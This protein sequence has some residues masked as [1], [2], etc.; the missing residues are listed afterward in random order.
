MK[1]A[2]QRFKKLKVE[3]YDAIITKDVFGVVPSL[4][5]IKIQ[6]ASNTLTYKQFSFLQ[7]NEKINAFMGWLE[8]MENK[9][10]LS[11]VIK[12]G[13]LGGGAQPWSN[14]YIQS[15]YS[16]GLSRADSE[17]KK[18]GHKIYKQTPIGIGIQE[19]FHVDRVAMLYTRTFEDL[20]TVTSVMN[21]EI[22]RE[23]TDGL[24]NIL[25]LG[26]AGGKGPASLTKDLYDLISN[27]VDKIGITRA[28]TIARTEVIR[29]HHQAT[30]NEYEQWGIT[31]VKILAEWATA[32]FGVCPICSTLQ[33][34]I[35][36]LEEI[37]GLIPIHPNCRC[38]A[39]PYIKEDEKKSV[40]KKVAPKKV[41]PKKVAPKKVEKEPLYIT[42]MAELN[43]AQYKTER[44]FAFND[45]GKQILKKIGGET[46]ISFNKQEISVLNGAKDVVHNHP[47][48]TSFSI[49]DC[50][51]QRTTGAKN[52]WA[53]GVDYNY[54]MWDPS[55]SKKE[56]VKEYDK[57]EQEMFSLLKKNMQ[58]KFVTF[59]QA[60]LIHH[61]HVWEE[62]AK[63][64][65][66]KYERI[67]VA[68]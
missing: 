33:N 67:P 52:I 23:L 19:P 31:G 36:T 3:I 45:A 26:M 16:I 55:G 20:K 63:K 57:V 21:N 22:R 56:F 41:A 62:M 37:R 4:Q 30:I 60:F 5:T 49:E 12:P 66:L 35:Y 51:F 10:I 38:C 25:S 7:S 54:H 58:K 27:R 61:H 65:W 17:M 40:A 18:V 34:K 11:T 28:K 43:K 32:G 47:Q 68:R 50:M 2:V 64:G 9:H 39:I 14:L 44:I 1:E 42:K 6:A 53:T 15:A 46:E 8:E 59:D 24:T 29:A 48:G 13:L